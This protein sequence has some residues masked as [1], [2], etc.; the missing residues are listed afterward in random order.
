[1]YVLVWTRFSVWTRVWS[2]DHDC[3]SQVT[4]VVVLRTPGGAVGAVPRAQLAFQPLAFQL[5]SRIGVG[6]WI[7][8]NAAH[9]TAAAEGGE[10]SGCQAAQLQISSRDRCSSTLVLLVLLLVLLLDRALSSAK[11]WTDLCV[12]PLRCASKNKVRACI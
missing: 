7:F 10:L 6:Y 3:G 8:P 4:W 11:R 12:R 1:M 2:L 5:L 9:H